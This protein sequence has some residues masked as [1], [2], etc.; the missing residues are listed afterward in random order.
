M[1][2]EIR[3]VAEIIEMNQIYGL[4]MKDAHIYT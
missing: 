4:E 1:K 3:K 2:D